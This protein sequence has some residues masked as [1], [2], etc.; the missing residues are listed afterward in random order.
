[1]DKKT[2]IGMVLIFAI[3]M[4]WFYY[5]QPSKEELARQQ[6]IRDSINA[7]ALE[8]QHVKDSLFQIS[9]QN[10]MQGTEVAVLGD[11]VVS[12]EQEAIEIKN[13]F[14]IFSGAVKSQEEFYTL[15]NEVFR[16]TIS[17]KGGRIYN[18][19]LKDYFRF[20]SMPLVIF[21]STRSV[22]DMG[23]FSQNKPMNTS[24]FYFQPVWYDTPK[25]IKDIK[26]EGA[27]SL[28]FGMRLYADVDTLNRL[29]KYIEFLYT[30]KK[31]EYKLGFEVIFNNMQNDIQAQ[32]GFVNF[33][34]RED[35]NRQEKGLK[36]ERNTTTIYYRYYNDDVES[37]HETKDRDHKILNAN[38]EWVSFKSR[39]FLSTLISDQYFM[40][41]NIET[42]VDP[43]L[44]KNEN[45]LQSMVANIGLP[46]SSNE[47]IHSIPMNFYFGP[48][49]YHTLTNYGQKLNRQVPIGWS[50][51]LL[52]WINK[53][54]IWVFD[55]MSSWNWSYGLIV[56]MLAVLIKIIVFPITMSSYKS[57]AV[58]RMLKP[59]IDEINA[60][61]PKNEDM[62]KKQ[63]ATMKLYKQAGVSPMKGC[64]PM[65]LQMPILFA[66]FRFFP[67][68]IEL[69]Q[70][71]FLWADDLSSYDSI[72][73][74]GFNIPFY[75]D[76]VSLFTIL[77]TISTIIYTWLN[78][79][80]MG[81]A[82]QM[83][84]MKWMMY[85][86]PIMF[87][88]IFNN[89][90][91]SLSYYYLIINLL[92]FAQMF[93][94]RKMVNEEKLRLKLKEAKTKPIKKSKWQIRMEELA[95]KQQQL[96]KR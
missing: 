21:D 4:G 83:P 18:V 40:N 64:I 76:H 6:K 36:E 1:M 10:K 78:N 75:G 2:I 52:A 61:Y 26:L 28:R 38:I 15:E 68:S 33:E 3:F 63:Q 11:K 69:R 72:L 80:Q 37:L 60:R 57:S 43:V 24:S 13:K 54:V 23:F 71:S 48:N 96:Q 8:Q 89:Y 16:I 53:G 73:D 25:D 39:F 81:T 22:F 31:D 90:A 86:M 32:T 46:W 67:S 93:A 51:F 34:W 94:A 47:S 41:T 17:N 35:L 29:D 65:L 88:G 49:K 79:K 20:D 14:G 95:K 50:F 42:F 55:L 66:M 7:V 70:Q 77:M 58:M 30:L 74:L 91:A 84:A 85:L 87:L 59:D 45:Y 12:P 56:F 5:M 27:D 9:E 19:V 62:M 44:S 82:N 92:T